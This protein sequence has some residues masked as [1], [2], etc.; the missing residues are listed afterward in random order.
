MQTVQHIDGHFLDREFDIGVNLVVSYY[1][2]EVMFIQRKDF[3]CRMHRRPSCFP[4]KQ[5]PRVDENKASPL[6]NNRFDRNPT[7]HQQ[8]VIRDDS[9]FV[10]V[11][12]G[13][14]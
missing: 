1:I 11:S 8:L 7:H 13:R 9:S 4:P 6:L 5:H 2:L 14:F 12:F 10:D 3:P